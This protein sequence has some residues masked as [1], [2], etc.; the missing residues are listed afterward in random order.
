[1]R[2]KKIINFL[3]LKKLYRIYLSQYQTVNI[4]IDKP[5]AY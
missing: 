4:K 2:R 3:R 1:M 5:K